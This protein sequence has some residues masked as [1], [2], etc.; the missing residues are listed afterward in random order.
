[1]LRL[2]FI[3]SSGLHIKRTLG[4]DRYNPNPCR[5]TILTLYLTLNV[6]P[7]PHPTK[8]FGVPAPWCYD[9]HQ[10]WDTFGISESDPVCLVRRKQ[11]RHQTLTLTLT[12][13]SQA[14]KLVSTRGETSLVERAVPRLPGPPMGQEPPSNYAPGRRRIRTARCVTRLAESMVY[15]PCKKGNRCKHDCTYI[16]AGDRHLLYLEYMKIRK[17]VLTLTLSY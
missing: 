14:R 17:E 9:C 2:Q 15:E 3:L 11:T 16:S 13:S 6:N 7:Y 4:L 10:D 12:F 1:M 8:G 5:L